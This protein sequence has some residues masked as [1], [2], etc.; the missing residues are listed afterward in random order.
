MPGLLM[1]YFVLKPKGNDPYAKASREALLKYAEFIEGE[2]PEMASDLRHWA[3]SE[4]AR[5][6]VDALD[7]LA[8]HAD[9][10]S[11]CPS[12]LASDPETGFPPDGRGRL[13]CRLR[14]GLLH[15][16]AGGCFQGKGRCP[17]QRPGRFEPS[18][19]GTA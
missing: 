18:R 7:A 14:H 4:D 13:L 8:A 6:K 16:W 15:P 2:N 5:I 12:C 11:E 1:K 19:R 9:Y 3:L 10:V 17:R